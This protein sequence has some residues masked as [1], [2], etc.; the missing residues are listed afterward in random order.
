MKKI[1]FLLAA[2]TCFS[3]AAQNGIDGVLSSV[4]DNNTTL[5]ALRESMEA[6]K[7]ENRTGIFLDSPEVGFNYLWG[8]PGSIG[9]RTDVSVSQRF[10]VATLSGLKSKV[11]DGQNRMAELQ[12]LAGRMDI[13]LEAKLYSIDL[14]HC[15]ALLKEMTLRRDRAGAIA[16]ACEQRLAQGDAN[17]LEYNKA[18][19]NFVTAEGET[20]RIGIERDALLAELKKLN[21]GLDVSLDDDRF[22]DVSF[23]LDFDEWYAEAERR[24]PVLAYVRQEVEVGRT[25]VGLNRAMGLPALSGGYMSETVAGEQFRGITL[26]I[27]IP[28]WEN[29]NRVRQAKAAVRAA[30]QRSEDAKLQFYS[31][32][33]ILYNRAAGLRLSAEKYRRSLTALSNADLLKKALDAGEISLLEYIV[34]TGLLYETVNKTLEAERDFYRAYAE[35]SAVML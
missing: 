31:R 13:M 32:L 9:N 27:S 2:G 25:R 1:L 22:G 10:D 14:I 24:N 26:G 8:T 30:E 29:R 17:R 15:N 35:L 23:P 6:Q 16:G 33:Q 11:A 20:A 19:L 34:E 12:Y 21:G 4:E 28:L 18:Q 5:K 7:L 3:L